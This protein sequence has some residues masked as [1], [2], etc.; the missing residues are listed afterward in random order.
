MWEADSGV[1]KIFGKGKQ[2]FFVTSENCGQVTLNSMSRYVLRVFGVTKE[3]LQKNELQLQ[4]LNG[5]S[6]FEFEVF[7]WIFSAP[8]ELSFGVMSNTS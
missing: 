5:V 4:K 8:S 3:V 7:G 6:C 1:E 2:F